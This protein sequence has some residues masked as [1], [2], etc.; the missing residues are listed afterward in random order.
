MP[1]ARSRAAVRGG[2]VQTGKKTVG[3]RGFSASLSI[4]VMNIV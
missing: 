3:V 2:A 4:R 1:R